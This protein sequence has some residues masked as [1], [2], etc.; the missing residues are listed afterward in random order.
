MT[1]YQTAKSL[2]RA[3]SK[4]VGARLA[5]SSGRAW[6]SPDHGRAAGQMILE[7]VVEFGDAFL[8]HLLEALEVLFRFRRC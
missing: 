5:S 3:G 1:K 7:N 2:D 4:I 8:D 6:Y